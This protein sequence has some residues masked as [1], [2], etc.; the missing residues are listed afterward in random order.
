MFSLIPYSWRR[1]NIARKDDFFGI[2]RFFE[3]FF[4][5]P[6]FNRL[7]AMTTPIRTDIK[8]TDEKY[9]IEAELPGVK[10]EDII[11]ELKDNV[12]TLGVDVKNEAKK[13]DNGYICKERHSGS[14]R[15]SFHV[16]NIKNEDV[17]AGY[18]DGLLTITLPKDKK[19]DKSRRIKI[20]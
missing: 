4:K 15:R 18:K 1:G 20:E 2:D 8:E 13:E 6:F 12:L 5:D 10:K 9:I 3:D 17:K 19:E 14:Y 11:I 7:S 16:E